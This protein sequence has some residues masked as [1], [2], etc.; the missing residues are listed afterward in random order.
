M[1]WHFIMGAVKIH[2]FTPFALRW[3]KYPGLKTDIALAVKTGIQNNP[4]IVYGF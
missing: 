3:S 4:K 1:S 2:R